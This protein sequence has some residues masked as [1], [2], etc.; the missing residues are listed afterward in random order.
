MST[1]IL[2]PECGGVIF[3]AGADADANRACTCEKPGNDNTAA[4]AIAQG[5]VAVKVCVNCGADLTN[6][7]R[8]KDKEGN[9]WCQTCGI[10]D[11]RRK[12]EAAI[13][14]GGGVVVCPDC[15]GRFPRDKMHRAGADMIC[16]ACAI[17]R[18]TA[19]KKHARKKPVSGSSVAEVSDR[20]NKILL[21]AIALLVV[22]VMLWQY[23]SH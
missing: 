4:T 3:A 12:K 7:K 22:V 2:C 23:M 18:V 15:C 19:G 8:L 20:R 10:E 9:Y 17:K 21:L 16:E 14:A 13:K 5:P 6:A 11:H 1:E